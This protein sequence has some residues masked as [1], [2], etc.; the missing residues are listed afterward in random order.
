MGCIYRKLKCLLYLSSQPPSDCSFIFAPV[1]ID[2]VS[3]D[4]RYAAKGFSNTHHW[5]EAPKEPN[6]SRIPA[7]QLSMGVMVATKAFADMWSTGQHVELIIDYDIRSCYILFTH[8]GER[9]RM[10]FD[11]S[12]MNGMMRL[13]RD[14]STIYLT[15]SLQYPP[16]V[17]RQTINKVPGTNDHLQTQRNSTT[18]AWERV[19]H[20]P[21]DIN[22]KKL[23]ETQVDNKVKRRPVPP[24]PPAHCID[25][26]GWL[27]L[28]IKLD[29]PEYSQPALQNML[30][31]AAQFNLIPRDYQKENRLF[32]RVIPGLALNIKDHMYRATKIKD[33]DVLYAL[34]SAV[35]RHQV[36]SANLD[37]DFY[38]MMNELD[39]SIAV[40]LLT[41][42]ME[43]GALVRDPAKF[44]HN[45][46]EKKRGKIRHQQHI[47]QHC[48]A[49]RKV[50][51]TPTTIYL[52]PPVIEVTNRVVRH[53]QQ[54][55][56]RFLRVQFVDDGMRHMPASFGVEH[57]EALYDRVY[58]VLRDGIQIGT[59]RYE[60]LA[61]SSSQLRGHGCWFFAPTPDLN[62]KMIRSWMGSF[63]HVKIIAKNAVRMGQCFSST[64]P[65]KDLDINQVEIIDDIEFN[66]YCFSDG[67]G[68]ISPGL[69][70]EVAS[71]LKLDYTPSCFQFRLSGAKGVLVISNY[72]SGKR[73]QLRPSQIK[74]ESKYT[75][76]EVIR[77]A[78]FL[79]A[80]L[81]RQ[82]II[83]LSALGVK[84]NI[85]MT[86]TKNAI[87]AMDLM[88]KNPSTSTRLLTQNLD[89]F[90][91]AR[92]MIS[93]INSGFLERQDPY[94]T[95]LLKLFRASRMKDL[96]EKAKIQ[97][98]KGAFLLGVLDETDSL[99]PN[100]VF[101]QISESTLGSSQKTRR[102]IEGDC[103]IF[104]NPCFH[105]GDVRVVTAVNCP[106]LRHLC[107]VIV[108][109]AKGYRDL[110]SMLSGGD[111]DEE[112]I[113]VDRV[114][115]SHIQKFFVNYMNNDNLGQ[116]AHAH[117]ATA[118]RSPMGA[119]DGRC[120]RLAQ[121][122]SRAVDFPKSGKPAILEEDLRVRVFPDFMQ[123]KDK[124]SYK[125]EKVLGRIYRSIN[126]EDYEH[127][128]EKL[129]NLEATT[130]DVRLW[131][132][133]MEQYILRARE[134]K[135]EYDRDLQSLMNQY[136]VYTESELISG[137]VMEWS[138]IADTRSNTFELCKRMMR[139]VT[140]LREKYRQEY[141]KK[142]IIGD[143][144]IYQ[145]SA[146]DRMQLET[147]AAAWYYVTYHPEE[148]RRAHAGSD[149]ISFPWIHF[150]LLCDMARRNTHREVLPQM[151][152]ALDEKTIQSYRQGGLQWVDE[153]QIE[154]DDED[155]Q[156]ED[157]SDEDDDNSDNNDQG[158]DSGTEEAE[159]PIIEVKIADL[160]KFI[161][162]RTSSTVAKSI[163][164]SH[165]LPPPPSSSTSN[166]IEENDQLTSQYLH[167]SNQQTD[168]EMAK[169]LFS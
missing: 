62:P 17:K 149:F 40:S 92:A 57:N 75:M 121:L 79:P 65:T 10:R 68:K 14:G 13:E 133:N 18:R 51:V 125:S 141:F 131:T 48:M 46:F 98:S 37:D 8:L 39:P 123:K 38:D 150:E 109:P 107:D 154:E 61:F 96:K 120:I 32:L 113:E 103:I 101:C 49:T 169:V 95:N 73:L 147:K 27:T 56:N 66:G 105:P 162:Q 55:S 20:I 138:Q 44:C 128:R 156:D 155:E 152:Q 45:I 102:V 12:D 25:L 35:S 94:I 41:L 24:V 21:V 7:K 134:I 167:V 22:A 86:M 81:N 104:R 50:F 11:F 59:R 16:H 145:A 88:L 52:Q 30:S 151:Y 166:T 100:E 67:I 83:L 110:P 82:A 122:H 69:A 3:V 168:E 129:V 135:A 58:K 76:F 126:Q 157:E 84:D 163:S 6:A 1:K 144:P 29:P 137:F 118:D 53:F 72:L 117:L 165:I 74:F 47:P 90:G 2:G 36:E 116:I 28:R 87:D 42:L 106:K 91:T 161:S 54:Y 143:R 80:Y 130:Y 26:G 140:S 124:E 99:E 139:A 4:I 34:E 97:V 9:Y 159:H 15:M 132:T 71:L 119:Q 112:P 63:D 43:N 31:Q 23:L 89:E 5:R 127:Y 70:R 111:L 64:T 164:S 115:I 160:K 153:L 148:R 78:R 114:K 108:F 93:I 60:F 146:E 33:F 136:G 85:F 19:V 158:N 142:D 77:V